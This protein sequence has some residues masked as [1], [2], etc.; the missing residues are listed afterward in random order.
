MGHDS[1]SSSSANPFDTTQQRWSVPEKECYAIWFTLRRLEHLL[2]DVPFTLHTDHKN[3]TY[4]ATTGSSKV[5]RSKLEVRE[6]DCQVQ[7]ITRAANS[8]ADAFIPILPT[9]R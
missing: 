8:M 1:Q 5:L 6:Y 7:Y 3:L 9:N 2:R 4:F